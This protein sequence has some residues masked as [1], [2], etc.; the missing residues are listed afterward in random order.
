[1]SVGNF[2]KKLG[3]L[4]FLVTVSIIGYTYFF[5]DG[6]SDNFYLR[7]TTGK[8]PSLVVG[9]SRG[10]QAIRPDLLNDSAIPFA[11]PLYNYCFSVAHSPFGKVYNDAIRKKIGSAPAK[12]ALFIVEVSPWAF[13]RKKDNTEDDE[14]RYI[15]Q[16]LCLGKIRFLNINPNLEYAFTFLN[17][18]LYVLFKDR[19]SQLLK[20]ERK[21]G[22][23]LSADGWLEITIPMDAASIRKRQARKIEGLQRVSNESQISDKRFGHFQA[24][25]SDLAER[26][27]T[28]L[29]RLPADPEVMEIEATLW[30][31][32]NAAMAQTANIADAVYLDLTAPLAGLETTDGSHL[33]KKS[34]VTVTAEIGRQIS[35]YRQKSRR[36]AYK[37]LSPDESI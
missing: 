9:T 14:S 5:C 11:R 33:S 13:T 25:V 15:E 36:S 16:E 20:G 29:V 12:D 28:F 24:L 27:E 3:L 35:I 30:P 17:K 1:M 26:G 6:R 32:F 34:A 2:L 23:R 18:P 4:A 22:Q 21:F 19:I 7:L 31:D 8:F 10:A 37:M